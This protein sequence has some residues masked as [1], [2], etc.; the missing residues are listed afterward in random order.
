MEHE[1]LGAAVGDLDEFGECGHVLLHVDDAAGVV[2][3]H[4]EEVG[5]AHVDRRRLDERFVERLDDDPAGGQLFA[6]ASVGEDH[7]SAR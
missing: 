6:K 4:P 1:R 2:A 3:E 7:E 5:D